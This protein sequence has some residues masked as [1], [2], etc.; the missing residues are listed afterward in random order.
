MDEPMIAELSNP[1]SLREIRN[2][3]IGNDK[4]V[5]F[6]RGLIETVVPLINES[7]QE[8]TYECLV[9]LNSFLIDFP[10]AIDV[11]NCL[12][13]QIKESVQ[14]ILEKCDFKV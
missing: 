2:E 8:M 12:A 9:I 4:R 14:T 5:L 1:Q 6:N 11:F 3:L 13:S 7:D 10:D